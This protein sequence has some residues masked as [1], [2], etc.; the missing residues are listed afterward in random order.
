MVPTCNPI[1]KYRRVSDLN[2]LV[3]LLTNRFVPETDTIVQQF[4]GYEGGLVFKRLQL[5]PELYNW[6]M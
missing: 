3:L 2:E 6:Y 5:I 4:R 1:S